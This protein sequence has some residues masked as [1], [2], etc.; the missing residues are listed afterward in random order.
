MALAKYP[1]I[2]F[3][4]EKQR[5]AISILQV[6]EI[7]MMQPINKVPQSSAHILGVISVRGKIIPILSLR[8]LFHYRE[9][10]PTKESRIILISYSNHVYGLVVDAVHRVVVFEAV[11]PPPEKLGLLKGSAFAGIGVIAEEIVA[12][13]QPEHL[14]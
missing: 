9:L 7:V 6:Q 8:K 3:E 1:Y 11:Q 13:V 14:I 4:I 5:Y 2:E 10:E 12:I